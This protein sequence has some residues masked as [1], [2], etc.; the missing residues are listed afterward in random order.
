M[1]EGVTEL[2]E[3]WFADTIEVA[4]GESS[5]VRRK[6]APDMVEAALERLGVDKSDAVYVGDS[7]VDI[8]TA[9]NSG[10]PCVSVLWGF[11]DREFLMAHGA[12][13]MIEKP[14]ELLTNK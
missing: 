1:Q 6:P 10:L 4:I 9:R 5:D 2:H 3:K 8:A 7:D 12:Q 13:C 11:R 14:Q